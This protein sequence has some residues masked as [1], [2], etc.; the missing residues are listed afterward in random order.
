ME[1]VYAVY[2]YNLSKGKLVTLPVGAKPLSVIAQGEELMMYALVDVTEQKTENKDFLVLGTGW[3]SYGN[4]TEKYNFL[5]TV[6][7]GSYVWHV[8]IEK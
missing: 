1:S 6:V 7:N 3:E 5:G 2:K 8:W 4:P